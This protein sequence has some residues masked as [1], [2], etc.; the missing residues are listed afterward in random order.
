MRKRVMIYGA[1]AAGLLA[2]MKLCGD[3][4]VI[5][6]DK[7]RNIGQKLLVA[8]KGGLNIT[9]S[10]EIQ[11]LVS[12]YSPPGFLDQCLTDNDT[13][14][15]R[16]WLEQNG[17][18]TYPGSSGKVFPEKGISVKH[19]LQNF[20]KRLLS[21]GVEFRMK[22][23]FAGFNDLLEPLIETRGKT[24][25]ADADFHIFA[26]GG[27]SWPQTGSD[28]GW[29]ELFRS[30][31]F[32][33]LP[34]EASNCG[35]NIQWPDS[36]S[37][38]HAG[39]PLK[40]IS[41]NFRKKSSKGEALLTETGLEGYALYPLI[42]LIREALKTRESVVIEIDLKPFSSPEQLQH[43]LEGKTIKPQKYAEILNLNPIQMALAKTLTTKET[44]L[45]SQEFAAAIK[46][47]PIRIDS[48]R[49]IEEA[50]SSVGGLS[51]SELNSN[52]SLLRNSKLFAIG[53][54]VNW[55]A[56]TGGFL[57]QACFSM[58]GRVSRAIEESNP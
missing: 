14:A 40:N 19:I 18:Q 30:A 23:R 46:H 7:E 51:V 37:K 34:F 15:F 24:E 1:G 50:I 42:P 12:K 39:K 20:K 53:E 38:F 28:G 4:E 49:P 29:L 41:L 13:L 45:N 33:V 57:L 21:E 27:A 8:G 3:H 22:S 32:E 36:I 56:P 31:G 58:A 47:L 25:T 17:I 11:D 26:L 55:D 43:K 9:N 16:A 54:M 52:F 35:V 10:V 48:L 44:Y 6:I 2:A 5:V